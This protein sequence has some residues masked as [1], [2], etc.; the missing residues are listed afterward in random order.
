MVIAGHSN[1]VDDLAAAF[2]GPAINEL[3]HRDYD[4]IFVIHR[5]NDAPVQLHKQDFSRAIAQTK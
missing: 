3:E 2:G 5:C 4:S 1:T